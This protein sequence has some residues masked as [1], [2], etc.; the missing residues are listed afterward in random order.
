MLNAYFNPSHVLRHAA[1]SIHLHVDSNKDTRIC[2]VRGIAE[3]WQ[4][5]QH[6]TLVAAPDNV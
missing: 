3:P 4:A 6:P 1:L 2:F 5:L